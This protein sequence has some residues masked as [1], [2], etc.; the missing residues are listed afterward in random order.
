MFPRAKPERII[1][2]FSIIAL[3]AMSLL[4]RNNLLCRYRSLYYSI[5]IMFRFHYSLHRSI[6]ALHSKHNVVH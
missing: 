1:G 5:L 6:A 2:K 4:K 3:P